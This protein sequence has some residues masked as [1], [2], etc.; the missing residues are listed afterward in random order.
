MI[1]MQTQF[2][3]ISGMRKLLS[4]HN[5]IS[6]SGESGT[7][8]TTLTLQLVGSFLTDEAPYEDSC[9]WVQASELFSLTRLRQIFQDQ[10]SKLE[11]IQNNIFVIPH[12]RPIHTYEQQISLFQRIIHPEFS[13][14]PSLKYIVIDNISH[15]L[16][17]KLNQYN[18]SKDI[19]SLLNGFYEMILMPLILFCRQHDIILILIHEITYSPKDECNRPFFYKLYDRIKTIDIELSKEYNNEKKSLYLFYENSTWN[20]QYT[21]GNGGMLII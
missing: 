2:D 1:N 20:F 6:I 16:R 11:Y 12:N 13:I 21:L 18:D 15:H 14:P 19:S 17:Y 3:F 8:K 10:K 9:I 5:I 4:H 7:G